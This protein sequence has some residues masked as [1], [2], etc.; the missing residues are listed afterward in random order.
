LKVEKITEQHMNDAFKI[1]A[2]MSIIICVYMMFNYDIIINYGE[3]DFSSNRLIG[4][5]RIV[6]C[7][8]QLSMSIVYAYYWLR[9]KI[10]EKPEK[11]TI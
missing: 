3:A 7:L 5:G 11:H 4:L 8:I 2:F 1:S 9:F 10:W 6:L